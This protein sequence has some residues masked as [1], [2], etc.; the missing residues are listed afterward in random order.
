MKGKDM[1]L[2]DFLSWQRVDKSNPHKIIPISFDMKA[3]LKERYYNIGNESRYS[4]QMCSKI[5]DSGIKLPEVHGTVTNTIMYL[6]P[7]TLGILPGTYPVPV[8][9]PMGQ[10]IGMNTCRVCLW[11]R[12][13]PLN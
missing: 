2:S 1:I 12:E 11:N 7:G 3:I 10:E 5:K 13:E 6:L 8:S 4:V 9:H